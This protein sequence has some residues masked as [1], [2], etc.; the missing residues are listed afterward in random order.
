MTKP[1][2]GEVHVYPYPWFRE[3]NAGE[4]AGRKDR[5]VCVTVAVKKDAVTHLFLVPI[6]STPP[7]AGQASIA[8]HDLE[9][10]RAGLDDRKA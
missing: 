10:R 2:V 6:T 5:P 1:E 4:D 7:P 8:V 3:H 9:A